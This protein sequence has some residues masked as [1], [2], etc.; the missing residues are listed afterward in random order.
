MRLRQLTPPPYR[1]CFTHRPGTMIYL[2]GTSHAIQIFPTALRLF[3]CRGTD[4]ELVKEVFLPEL[5]PC[6]EWT[7]FIDSMR[8]TV[9]VEGRGLRGF[10]RY[11]IYAGQE[12][13]YIKPAAGTLRLVAHGVENDVTKGDPFPL[14][15]SPAILARF[16]TPRL[17]LGCHKAPLWDRICEDPQMEELLPL[18]YQLFRP[19]SLEDIAPSS[20]LFG[21]VVQS[22]QNAASA[23][24]LPAL[25]TFFRVGMDGYFVPK[26][27]DDA[28]LGYDTPLLPDEMRLSEVHAAI[29]A[30]IR[31]LFIQE[32]GNILSILPCLPKEL[33]CGRLL[34]ETLLSGHQV[35]IEWRK[36]K[37]RRILLHAKTDGLVTLQASVSQASIRPI[38]GKARK[39]SVA[40]GKEIEVLA[41]KV[42]LLDNFST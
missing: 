1:P 2:S 41:G 22:V 13:V 42:Y 12:G 34:H 27:V 36:G 26:R 33:V 14:T 35:D 30:L 6:S 3:D 5:G 31:S 40:I 28:F 7:V 29:C 17:L 24:I 4:R 18:W 21:A 15:D 9:R 19:A 11:H 39:R 37:I 38:G 23:A 10:F 8:Q 16:P 25:A 32:Q 20:T